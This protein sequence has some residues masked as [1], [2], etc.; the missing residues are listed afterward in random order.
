MF[1][2]KSALPIHSSFKAPN[3]K[4]T[5]AEIA[6][7]MFISSTALSQSLMLLLSLR[8]PPAGLCSP[9]GFWIS[10]HMFDDTSSKELTTGKLC[11]WWLLVCRECTFSFKPL[12]CNIDVK[13]PCITSWIHVLFHLLTST[14]LCS[15][16]CVFVGELLH[17]QVKPLSR[18]LKF[19]AHS[20]AWN[21]TQLNL[22][23]CHRHCQKYSTHK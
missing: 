14:L 6:S 13:R 12:W 9:K 19:Q 3:R 21:T 15:A 17:I 4:V 23:T 5:Q 18:A 20:W 7:Q 10:T 16:Q 22:K 8:T 1:K 2:I 11:L